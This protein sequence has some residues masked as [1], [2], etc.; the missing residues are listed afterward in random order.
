MDD[1]G[2]FDSSKWIDEALCT[3]L[4][5]VVADNIFFP[6]D[7]NYEKGIAFCQPCP[8]KEQCLSEGRKRTTY[9]VFGGKTPQERKKS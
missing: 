1:I 9:G 5:L 6:E 7:E 3:K 8:V 2:L 4:P